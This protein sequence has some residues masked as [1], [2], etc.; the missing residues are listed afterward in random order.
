MGTLIVVGSEIY[1][2]DRKAGELVD[3][4]AAS[5]FVLIPKQGCVDLRIGG[6]SVR[7]SSSAVDHYIASKLVDGLIP[8]QS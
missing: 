4:L 8:V 7:T 3:Q 6:K 1:H 5:Q 2:V